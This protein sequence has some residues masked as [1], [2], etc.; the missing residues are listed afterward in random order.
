MPLVILN[1]PLRLILSSVLVL[2]GVSIYFT[3]NRFLLLGQSAHDL[4][5]TR[6]LVIGYNTFK[7]FVSFGIVYYF[8]ISMVF[9]IYVK[10]IGKLGPTEFYSLP[11]SQIN[12]STSK[13]A[14]SIGFYFKDKYNTLSGNQFYHLLK[15]TKDRFNPKR[16]VYIECRKSIFDSYLLDSYEVQ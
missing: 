16:E 15:D 4:L 1:T 14:P 9:N 12:P 7:Y 3:R 13:S 10:H 8:S 11:I 6:I 2:I 5:K